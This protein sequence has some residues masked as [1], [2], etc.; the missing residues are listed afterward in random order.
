MSLSQAH[1]ERRLL[2][3]FRPHDEW[4]RLFGLGC[5]EADRARFLERGYL[6]RS[7][8]RSLPSLHLQ[9]CARL[10]DESPSKIQALDLP[11]W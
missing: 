3:Q 4:G 10:K 9:F 11:P 5:L 6:S 1:A 7:Q 8:S 2:E